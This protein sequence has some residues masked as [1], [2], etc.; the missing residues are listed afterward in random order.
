V[1]PT[2]RKQEHSG[3]RDFNALRRQERRGDRD[4][5]ASRRREYSGDCDLELFCDRFDRGNRHCGVT[6]RFF[7]EGITQP[8][9]ESPISQIVALHHHQLHIDELNAF[10]RSLPKRG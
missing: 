6:G 7:A 4:F 9:F 3:D 8:F 5:D 2:H 10:A 1:T